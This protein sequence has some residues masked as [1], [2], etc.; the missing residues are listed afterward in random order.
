[1][2]EPKSSA[3]GPKPDQHGEQDSKLNP[4][5]PQDAERER[6]RNFP[7]IPDNP[8]PEDRISDGVLLSDQIK[9][10]VEKYQMIH[11]FDEEKSLKE[12]SYELRV[13]SKYGRAGDLLP[14]SRQAGIDNSAFRCRSHPNNGVP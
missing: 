5:S 4:K 1:M 6:L 14:I 10:L 3:N 7:D 13:G 12:A 8:V 9:R 2:P 11:P